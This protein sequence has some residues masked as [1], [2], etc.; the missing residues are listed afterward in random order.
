MR[1]EG[2]I[3]RSH[4]LGY[5]NSSNRFEPSEYLLDVFLIFPLLRWWW[6]IG[7]A[8]VIGRSHVEQTMYCL[9]RGLF[10]VLHLHT[11]KPNKMDFQWID[12]SSDISRHTERRAASGMDRMLHWPLHSRCGSGPAP[13]PWWC[14]QLW[15]SEFSCRHNLLS[16]RRGLVVETSAENLV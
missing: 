8:A 4:C 5:W 15:G 1:G 10:V 13:W 12:V 2:D 7:R 16:K 9:C 14:W 11:R 3:T 6:V